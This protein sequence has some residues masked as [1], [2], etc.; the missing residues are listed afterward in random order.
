MNMCVSILAACTLGVL[1]GYVVD[2]LIH[3]HWLAMCVGLIAALITGTLIAVFYIA[4]DRLDAL[5]VKIN[6]LQAKLHPH[7]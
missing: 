3:I 7:D 6:L 4:L 2:N 5:T 1:Q